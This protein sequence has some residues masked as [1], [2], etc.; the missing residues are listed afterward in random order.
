MSLDLTQIA[1]VQIMD[2]HR[3]IREII[4]LAARTGPLSQRSPVDL[5]DFGRTLFQSLWQRDFLV[6]GLRT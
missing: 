5:E 3:T 2:G 4:A 1:L 6:M